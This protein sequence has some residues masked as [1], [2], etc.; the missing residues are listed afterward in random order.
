[1]EIRQF[2]SFKTVVDLNSFSKAAKVLQY[3]QS[4]I[5]SHIQQLEEEIGVPLFDRLGKQIQL[6]KVGEELYQ[7]VLELFTVYEK[8]KNITTDL[9][10]MVGELRVGASETVTV[11]R[12]GPVL[13]QFK[14][15]FPGV[16]VS[17]MND[18]CPNLRARLHSG[19]LDIAIT[20]EPLVQ[21][22]QLTTE[23]CSVEPLVLVGE[24]NLSHTS[25]KQMD[26]QCLIM[27][28]K[29][30]SLRK[31][32]EHYLTKEGIDKSNYLEFSSMEAIKQCVMSGLGISLMPR[33]SVEAYLQNNQMKEIDIPEELNLFAQVS[34]HKN[35]WLSK[36]HRAFHNM[37]MEAFRWD[38]G[39][40]SLSQMDT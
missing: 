37:V 9:S 15:K 17:L 28:E 1:M 14:K 38:G 2:Q 22:E 33:I 25:L 39:T 26:N 8:I 5:T 23:I 4:S 35:K 27:T 20:L 24:K 21:D 34:Y 31:Y 7:H 19:E 29:D 30:C 40:G 12:L 6:T 11:Y 36:P 13:T 10:D 32:F 3:S 16:T 18:H